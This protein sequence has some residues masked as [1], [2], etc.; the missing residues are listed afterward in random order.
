MFLTVFFFFVSV[1]RYCES[2]GLQAVFKVHLVDG[3]GK[4]DAPAS[5][6]HG[7]EEHTLAASGNDV[8]QYDSGLLE[9]YPRTARG[10]CYNLHIAHII[11]SLDQTKLTAYWLDYEG[12]QVTLNDMVLGYADHL[13]LHMRQIHELAEQDDCYRALD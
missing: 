8:G 5:V 11:S 6:A 1:A 10:E 4:F 9:Q 13:E 7:I 3:A 2:Y 12:H